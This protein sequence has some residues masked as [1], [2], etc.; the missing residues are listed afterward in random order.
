M[1]D[2]RETSLPRKQTLWSFQHA[3]FV[4]AATALV[5]WH[6]PLLC[7]SLVIQL[8]VA[9]AMFEMSDEELAGASAAARLLCETL[10]VV[11]ALSPFQPGQGVQEQG[12]K[13]T[14]READTWAQQGADSAGSTDAGETHRRRVILSMGQIQQ[15]A[16]APPPLEAQSGQNPAFLDVSAIDKLII[17]RANVNP[18]AN[19]GEIEQLAELCSLDTLCEVLEISRHRNDRS[20]VRLLHPVF[21][22]RIAEAKRQAPTLDHIL[23]SWPEVGQN[24]DTPVDP[25]LASQRAAME[26]TVSNKLQELRNLHRSALS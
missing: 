26:S 2:K 19:P 12:L 6:L 25:A 7:A 20:T 3:I 18:I 1:K 22:R 23:Q 9:F 13:R 10:P 5:P 21:G 14:A 11:W 17:T 24:T 15:L 8:P 16:Q 4:A